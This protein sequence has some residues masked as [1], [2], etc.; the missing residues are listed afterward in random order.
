MA[1][2]LS[3]FFILTFYLGIGLVL[4]FPLYF[5]AFIVLTIQS[6]RR[7]HGVRPSIAAL[8][9]YFLFAISFFTRT[10]GVVK[11]TLM[12]PTQEAKANLGA[13]YV[14]QLSYFSKANTY[15]DRTTGDSKSLDCFQLI[16][17]KPTGPTRYSYYCGHDVFPNSQGA[18]LPLRPGRDWPFTV[19]PSVSASGF[20]VFAI[21]N[22]DRDDFLDVWTINDSK[23]LSHLLDDISNEVLQD[24]VTPAAQA[25]ADPRVTQTHTPSSHFSTLVS[26]AYAKDSSPAS[27]FFGFSFLWLALVLGLV[28]RD[29]HRYRAALLAHTQKRASGPEPDN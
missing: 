14:A 18:P 5:I 22:I 12:K 29:F 11:Y 28:Y 27:S 4:L 19:L 10:P 20:T 23:V 3:A 26:C 6:F 25:Q 21:G 16:H 13:I 8:V 9:L 2:L 17:W 1:A 7:K 15:A 24:E